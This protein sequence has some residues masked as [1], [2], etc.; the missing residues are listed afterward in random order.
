MLQGEGTET[1]DPLSSQETR[2]VLSASSAF[3]VP[4]QNGHLKTRKES[5]LFIPI[6]IQDWD[7][8]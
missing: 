3:H 2:L 4:I 1:H 6:P 5:G 8:V 7:T